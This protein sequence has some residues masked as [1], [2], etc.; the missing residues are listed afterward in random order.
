[1]PKDTVGDAEG[2]IPRRQAL[3]K[4]PHPLDAPVEIPERGEGRHPHPDNEIVVHKAIV[5]LIFFVQQIHGLLPV[6][7]SGCPWSH[8]DRAGRALSI[9]AVV[10]E[11]SHNQH[12]T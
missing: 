6:R 9:K 3:G 10:A 5:P 4:V 2:V 12:S 1:M 7:G 8:R 11:T